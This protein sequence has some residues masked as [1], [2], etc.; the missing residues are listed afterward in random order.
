MQHYN[1]L[2]ILGPTASGK[3]ALAAHL[4]VLLN[5][6]VI[7][8]DSRQVYRGMDIGTGKDMADYYVNGRQIPVH[9]VDIVDAGYQYN[10]FEYQRD[11][12]KALGDIRSRGKFPVLCG[13]SGLYI[14]AVLDNYQLIRVPVNEEIRS[15]LKKKSLAELTEILK[16]YKSRLHNIT[17][18]VN[19][20]RAIRA[21]EIEDYYARNPRDKTEMPCINSLII[22]VSSD[23]Q[24]RRNRITER[25]HR[26]LKEG[27]IEEVRKLL[28]S[29][30]KPEDL[31]YYGLEYK[32]ITQYLTGDISYNDMVEKLNIAIHQF[33]KRQMTWFRKMER[34]GIV[35]HWIEGEIPLS[36]KIDQ[37]LEL[38]GRDSQH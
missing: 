34:Q 38:L 1:F 16:G 5:G 33:A 22:G 2:T 10:V 6:E 13:G 21:I 8:A 14:E 32:F 12:L 7:S 15:V 18:I 23:L 30:I 28:D 4:A 3:T 25:L 27:M 19:E 20:K 37:V 17:D 11:F 31:I 24:S 35:I 26:R 36:E 9:L 29:G